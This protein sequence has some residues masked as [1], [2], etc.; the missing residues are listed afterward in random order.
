MAGVAAGAAGV[1]RVAGDRWTVAALLG[2]PAGPASGSIRGRD[3]GA[4][5]LASAWLRLLVGDV[6]VEL[7]DEF[8][9]E[10]LARALAV[11]LGR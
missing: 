5:A 6:T 3:P 9:A 11:V 8:V 10:T 1:V 4:A 2:G 7:S